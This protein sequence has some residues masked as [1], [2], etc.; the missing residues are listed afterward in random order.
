MTDLPSRSSAVRFLKLPYWSCFAED[1]A[2]FLG[3]E[4][5]SVQRPWMIGEQQDFCGTEPVAS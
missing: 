3:S 5:S 4:V 1:A 2:E